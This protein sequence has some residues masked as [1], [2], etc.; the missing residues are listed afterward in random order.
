MRSL[1]A[2][3]LL[4]PTAC[5]AQLTPQQ[6]IQVQHISGVAFAPNGLDI[7]FTVEAA[8]K[9]KSSVTDVWL[10]SGRPASPYT[11]SAASY[12]P[13]W[14]PEG[15]Q[16][17][18]LSAESGT[19]ELYVGAPPSSAR[20][21]THHG[22]A[23]AAFRW[24]PDGKQIA[25]IAADAAS[26]RAEREQDPR[27]IKV[28]SGS[29]L[30]AHLWSIDTASK[31]EHQITS[32]AFNVLEFAWKPDRSGFIV[33]AS[34]RPDPDHASERI[35]GVGNRSGI[36]HLIFDPKAPIEQL[37]L[38]PDGQTIAY[39]GPHGSGATP[40]DLYVLASG[41][42]TPPRDLTS[43]ID[44][45]VARYLWRDNSTLIA[46]L[47]FGFVDRLYTI[48]T[49]GQSQRLAGFDAN[50][51]S[52]DLSS[53]GAIAFVRDSASDPPELYLRIAPGAASRPIT[54]LNS[55]WSGI[56][57]AKGELIHYTSFDRTQI[58]GLLLR[59]PRTGAARLPT[60]LW[61]H[62]GPIGR[63]ED[64]F[65]PEG[66]FLASHGYAVL[67][68]NIRGS[69]GYGQQL[70]DL[71]RSTAR[72]GSG[73]ANGTLKDIEAG[74]D[75]LVQRGITDPDRLGVGGW[76]AGGYFAGLAVTRSSRFKAAVAGSGFYDMLTDLGTEISSFVP[77]DTWAYG[78]FFDPATQI[79][80]HHDSPIATANHAHT[81]VL[82]LHGEF[83]RT[84][85]I[86]QVYEF[87]RALQS[88]GAP[89][90][91]VVY[92]RE[93]HSFREEAHI[94]SQLSRTL[95]WYDNYLKGLRNDVSI[96]TP[97]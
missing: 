15:R 49:S 78:N 41:G 8:P 40:S 23:I 43:S 63:W 76:S 44:R 66:Q 29:D 46:S 26:T 81:P 48:S 72:G 61:L 73:W 25:F 53:R 86:G 69:R 95:A 91:L 51:G 14:S 52:F 89:V 7:A 18:Y 9:G 38:S 88:Y 79:L 31:H 20:Q 68:P 24:S 55:N 75:A 2:L 17:A 65:N 28:V 11:R 83:D 64:R 74:A 62:G 80:L 56:S 39:V 16:I 33:L 37:E 3:A 85:T 35:Y 1:I 45:G 12:E 10:S 77:G 30:P 50:P 36:S 58:E 42:G 32:G 59:P 71:V 60:I 94:L 87:F 22:A 67:Y 5:W 57:C 13:Q 34:E 90:Q 19:P 27:I 70:I 47:E 54:A 21:L 4:G 84:D 6:A 93:G 97:R 82:L 92:P 96:N